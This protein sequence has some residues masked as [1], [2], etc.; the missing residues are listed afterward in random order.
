MNVNA[1]NLIAEK[2]KFNSYKLARKGKKLAF[3]L[4]RTLFLTSVS[5]IILFP[6]IYMVSNAFKPMAELNDPSVIWVPKSL[7]F[8][9]FIISGKAMNYFSSLLST[10]KL[11]IVSAIIQ[12]FSCAW[13]AYGFARFQFKERNLMFGL[14]LLTII[15]PQQAVLVPLYA[16]YAN[17]DFFY[18]LHGI[19]RIFP[20]LPKINLINSYLT[21]Y[22]PAILG[23]G[24]R[25]GFFIFIYRQ[26][27]K[28]L[29]RELEEAA[30]IDGAG[31]IKTF[32]RIVLPSS[33]V[34][35]LTVFIF[36][37]IWYW[38]EY[39]L[40]S[41]VLDQNQPLAV[42]LSQIRAGLKIAWGVSASTNPSHLRNLLMAGSLIFVAPVLLLYLFVQ[43]FFIQSIERVGI[44]G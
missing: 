3:S 24:V 15:L 30:W 39:M 26:F 2:E 42:A 38:N 43:R 37:I 12:V 36:S 33:G 13:V 29:P 7:T 25:S 8:E 11:C 41:L 16:N 4:F 14:V 10:F 40:S 19:R 22:L 21:F 1:K 35:V 9:N 27:F 34:A 20:A 28:G 6:L 5:Y 17:L 44:V 18:I 32:I 31:P 23:S